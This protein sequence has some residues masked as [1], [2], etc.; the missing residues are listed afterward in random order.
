MAR[1]RNIKPGIMANEKL[2]ECA[3]IARLLFTYLWMLADRTGRLED[4]PR[5]IG[6]Q[7]LPYDDVDPNDL[8]QQL[9][10]HGFILRYEVEGTQY[11][12]I[13]NFEKHQAPHVKERESTIPAPDKVGAGTGQGKCKPDTSPVLA[14]PDSLI[15]DS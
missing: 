10:D 8:L 3:P 7:A 2:A 5:R 12:Q 13:L 4:R 15:P 1:A 14:P 6:V 9:H 11:I